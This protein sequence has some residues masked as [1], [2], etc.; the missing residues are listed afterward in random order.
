MARAESA[1]A[2]VP[3]LLSPLGGGEG[4]QGAASVRARCRADGGQERGLAAQP[5]AGAVQRRRGI[6]R[7]TDRS[8]GGCADRRTAVTAR[9]QALCCW[10]TTEATPRRCASWQTRGRRWRGPAAR[11]TDR[12]CRLSA[13]PAGPLPAARPGVPGTPLGRAPRPPATALR[14]RLA[15]PARAAPCRCLGEPRRL[16]P[17]TRQCLRQQVVHTCWGKRCAR[18]AELLPPVGLEHLAC[19]GSRGRRWGKDRPE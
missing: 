2:P 1:A 4:R 11:A 15:A 16:G 18:A 7:C 9:A 17:S 13:V 10:D 6:S 8:A 12:P 19:R 14:Q 5:C 3:S